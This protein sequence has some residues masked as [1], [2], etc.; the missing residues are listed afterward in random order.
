MMNKAYAVLILS[1]GA[2]LA[3]SRALGGP[4]TAPAVAPAHATVHP[5]LAQSPHHHSGRRP[6][7]FFPT[8]GGLV[9]DSQ[10][11]Q[12]AVTPTVTGPISADINTT[13]KYDVPWDWAHRYPPGFFGT[14]P[15]PTARASSYAPGCPAQTM[16]VPGADGKDQTITV[17]RC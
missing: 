12:E 5:S 15:A 1:L 13:Y 2:A 11:S 8:T 7:N 10:P 16:T 3:A 9:W 6:G 14:P 4:A 17:V